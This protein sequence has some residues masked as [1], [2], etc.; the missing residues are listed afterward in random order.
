MKLTS[1]VAGEIMISLSAI[2]DEKQFSIRCEVSRYIRRLELPRSRLCG[3]KIGLGADSAD[4]MMVPT[5]NQ[6]VSRHPIC[7]GKIL[8]FSMRFLSRFQLFLSEILSYFSV[9][10]RVEKEKNGSE[11]G[12]KPP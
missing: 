5:A 9:N 12:G 3:C 4:E 8:S 2:A 1:D 6:R 10:F 7:T 11:L